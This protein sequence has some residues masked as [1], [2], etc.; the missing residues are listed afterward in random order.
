[1]KPI[2]FLASEPHYVDH[3]APLW[4]ALDPDERAWFWTPN[5]TA[6]ARARHHDIDAA[7]FRTT[8]RT[9]SRG[10]GHVVI[11]GWGDRRHLAWRPRLVLCEH[12][13]GQSY[14]GGAAHHPHYAGGRHR[15]SV[16]VFL[17]PSE[18]ALIANQLAL[19]D[20]QRAFFTGPMRLDR[21]LAQ[22]R[23]AAKPR[24]TVAVAFHWDCRVVPETRWAFPYYAAAV[25]TLAADAGVDVIGHAHPRAW[26]HLSAWY[27]R[28]GIRPERDFDR[29][30]AE[31]DL[32]AV[33]NSSVLYEF[34]ALD[35]PVV[36][37][38][39][40]WYR[41]EVQHGL[42]FWEYADVG[43]NVSAPGELAQAAHFALNDITPVADRRRQIIRTLYGGLV[44]QGTARAVAAL[45]LALP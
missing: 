5:K 21:Y 37:M 40:P 18:P 36:V 38:N 44:G 42:R 24:P 32:L 29:V 6:R 39:A 33:D 17:C 28:H 35:R 34:A 27:A 26:P 10:V 9:Q 11:A 31:A 30:V 16:D 25:Q 13:A 23:P 3:L 8:R 4:H 20:G 2:G 7:V 41:R 14:P 15:E 43:V 12:G 19:A 1:M 45:R 22:P